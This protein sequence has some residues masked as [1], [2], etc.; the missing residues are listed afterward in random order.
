VRTE[1]GRLLEGM[2]ECI[3]ASEIGIGY[4]FGGN[5]RQIYQK[6]IQP[7][8]HY[9]HQ[10][11]KKDPSLPNSPVAEDL[12]DPMELDESEKEARPKRAAAGKYQG[13]STRLKRKLPSRSSMQKAPSK[14]ALPEGYSPQPGKEVG[15]FYNSSCAR[16]VE[17]EIARICFYAIR[18]IAGIT[19]IVS[20]RR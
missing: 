20:I 2:C 4:S 8:E 9:I 18:A 17:T 1:S 10:R 11:R 16:F 19:C 12:L 5:I 13:P 14:Q 6:W 15:F 7:Y 3:D